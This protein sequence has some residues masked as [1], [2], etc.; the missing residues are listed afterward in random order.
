MLRNSKYAARAASGKFVTVY[1]R[2]DAE[3]ELVCKELDELLT[4]EDGPY[5]LSDLRYAAG[6]V[7]VRYGGFAARYCHS[8]TGRS[9]RPSRTTPAPW[10]RTVATRCS[11][12]RPG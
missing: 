7:Y 10:C 8:P 5:V 12:C 3:L 9:S 2:D 11:T 1:P 4:G 6:P